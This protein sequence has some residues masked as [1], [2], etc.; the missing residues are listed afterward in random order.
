MAAA[1]LPIAGL[2]AGTHAKS[3]LEAIRSAGAFEVV[4]LLDDA[5]ARAVLLGVPVLPAADGLAVLRRRGVRHAFAGIGGIGDGGEPRRGVSERLLEA[6]FEL[7]AIV[8]ASAAVSPWARLGRGVQVLAMAVV[9]A[10]AELGDGVLVNTGG[11]GGA[12]LPDRRLRAPG[13][14]G[15]A[16]R[17]GER[18]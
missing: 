15:G 2:G 12:R 4:A 7:P 18:R 17:R 3:L 5:P 14:A 8:H 10:D 6:G 13:A 9:N 11:R 1:P 16:R